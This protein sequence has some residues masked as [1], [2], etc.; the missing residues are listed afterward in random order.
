MSK[1]V[2]SICGYIYDE[3]VGQPGEGIAP[4]TSWVLLPE[5]WLCPVCGAS[6]ED[7]YLME[8]EGKDA[9]TSVDKASPH[10]AALPVD[11]F[12]TM[13][14]ETTGTM[15]SNGA[16]GVIFSNL[17]KGSEK[18]VL[19]KISEQF[20]ILADYYSGISVSSQ[21]TTSSAEDSFTLLQKALA[22]D[23]ATG[24][25]GASAVASVLPDR[26]A[27]R[28]LVWGEKVSKMQ[29]ALLS[30]FEKQQDEMLRNTNLYVCEICGFL[31]MGDEPPEIC[32]V[33]KVPSMKIRK[34]G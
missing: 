13:A 16:L 12:P 30:R 29:T 2:C 34:V 32:P 5:T 4:G 1:Y 24:Y 21:E 23:L 9:N 6:R 3:A 25:A 20:A 8:E 31:Y 15:W 26:G 22:E 11:A 27:L 10:S 14:L 7:F 19:P 18:Q 33:C 17:A 28:S